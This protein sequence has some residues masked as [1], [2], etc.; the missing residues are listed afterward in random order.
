MSN[1]VWVMDSTGNG[2]GKVI[3]LSCPLFLCPTHDAEGNCPLVV[4][5]AKT[6]KT[7]KKKERK[8]KSKSRKN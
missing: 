2:G 6:G 4:S 3:S 7:G 8:K 1:V 5:L